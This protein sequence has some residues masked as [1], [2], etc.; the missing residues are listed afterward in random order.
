MRI[1]NSIW[2]VPHSEQL[3]TMLLHML[4]NIPGAYCNDLI[5]IVFRWPECYHVA[6]YLVYLSPSFT[7]ASLSVD[8]RM[9][10]SEREGVSRWVWG[11]EESPTAVPFERKRCR[12]VF[13]IREAGGRV[14]K[15]PWSG[16]SSDNSSFGSSCLESS[17][18]C[19]CVCVVW[20]W[21][22][23]YHDKIHSRPTLSCLSHVNIY[24]VKVV[25]Y[26]EFVIS[27]VVN[28]VCMIAW[29]FPSLTILLYSVL[30]TKISPFPPLSLLLFPF[31]SSFFPYTSPPSP[32]L[33][34]L[35]WEE[36]SFTQPS[37]KGRVARKA[38]IGS[39]LL[40]ESQL[41]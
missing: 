32:L 14:L 23:V 15:R 22:H 27:T 9:S 33:P 6:S 25:W 16:E 8:S 38:V 35:F 37:L 3:P 31:P 19:V 24:L 21:T 36:R 7:F 17:K 29:Y 40:V 41:H 13:V 18:L 28:D 5:S 39:C 1:Y 34:L 11:E 30:F 10:L 12:R 20:R 26:S 2:H 4:C